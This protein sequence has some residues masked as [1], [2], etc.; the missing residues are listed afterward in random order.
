[1]RRRTADGSDYARFQY[2]R[3]AQT[4]RRRWEHRLSEQ[5]RPASGDDPARAGSSADDLWAAPRP[6][7]P[8]YEF[9]SAPTGP[10][11]VG[12]QGGPPA[13][14]PPASPWGWELGPA[15]GRLDVAAFGS[16]PPRS[17]RRLRGAMLGGVVV[18]ALVVGAAAGGAAGYLAGRTNFSLGSGGGISLDASPTEAVNRAPGS[19]AA[20]AAR[21][22][23]GVVKIEVRGGGALGTG[24]GFVIDKAGYIVTNSH[25]VSSGGEGAKIRIQ[26]NDK[27]SVYGK[28]VGKD[29][30][31]DLA[32]VR[33]RN[34]RGLSPLSLGDSDGVA[35]GDPVLAIGTPLGLAG[36][37][38]AGIISA[39]N[40]AVTAGEPGEE[41]TYINALQTDTAI[42]PGNSGGPLVNSRGEVIGV[43]SAIASIGGASAMFGGQAGNI[44]VGFA[45]PAE[46]ARR[47]VEQLIRNGKA[48]HPVIGATL[49]PAYA[50]EGAKIV[51]K[52]VG[53]ASAIVPGGPAD[54]AGIKPG[55]VVISL[56]GDRVTTADELIVGIRNHA[57]GETIKLTVRRGLEG[58][59]LPGEARRVLG[60]SA[61]PGR[62]GA[63]ER[64]VGLAP[65]LN[66]HAASRAE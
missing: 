50:G 11:Q 12:P 1:M 59:D 46:L 36:S 37:V 27:Q 41:P 5:D 17:P 30:S 57:P 13:V 24:T 40:R 49:D 38:T 8:L 55:D 54:K 43:N 42:N 56:D 29:M 7:G 10:I 60:L 18:T 23:P 66:R 6:D 16:P 26:F 22:L 4:R 25:V 3:A 52:A 51:T 45:I 21:V 63:N 20:I 33:V 19:V 14:G 9:G 28:L 48:V 62:Y 2:G 34:V 61:P 58:A 31:S 32:V 39:K 15:Y 53:G 65:T 64:R 47:T 35:V 44:G